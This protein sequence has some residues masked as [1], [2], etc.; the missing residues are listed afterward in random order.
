MGLQR[1]TRLEGQ[2][3]QREVWRNGTDQVIDLVTLAV[4]AGPS[5]VASIR[6]DSPDFGFW[7][8]LLGATVEPTADCNGDGISDFSQVATG[9]LLD[10][11]GDLLPD[12]CE[13]ARFDLND[14]GAVDGG[15]LSVLLGFWGPTGTVLPRADIDRDG[16]VNGYDLAQLLA[17]WGSCSP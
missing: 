16:M 14:S 9:E 5:R 2:R 15:D 12:E 8:F 6:L 4:P 7:T 13:C 11:D 1:L 3:R 17:N 10:N